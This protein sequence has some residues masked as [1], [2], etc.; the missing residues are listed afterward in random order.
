[1]NM[2]S[3]LKWLNVG[4]RALMEMGIVA[5]LGYWGYSVGA[6]PWSRVLLAII[7]PAIGFGIWGLIDFRST[8]QSAELLRLSAELLISGLAALS[9][10]SVGQH[11]LG[12]SLAGLSGLHH[13][14][15]YLSGQ[16]LLD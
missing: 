16:R 13:A 12:W 8:G 6:S 4:L 1:M 15:I 9:I 3:A 10:Y 5:G 14:L 7:V 2:I 11:L